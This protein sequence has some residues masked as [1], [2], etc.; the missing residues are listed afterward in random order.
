M[1]MREITAVLFDLDGTLLDSAPDLLATLDRLRAGLGLPPSDHAALRH[2]A[3]R[4]AAGLLQAGLGERADIDE[5]QLREKFFDDYERNLWLHTRAF[6]GVTALLAALGRSG[7]PMGIVTNKIS[8]FAE[9]I[10]VH[11]G[12]ESM[13]DC[14]VTGD[15]VARPKPDAEPVLTACRVLDVAPEQVMFLGDDRRDVD[16]GR[17][18]G[19]G[20]A[21]ATWGY[22]PPGEKPRQWGADALLARPADLLDMLAP[23]A[24]SL[25]EEP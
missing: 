12:W 8:R 24:A 16:A 4:G 7:I 3:S 18:A 15:R 22:I 21:V 25:R 19:A 11:A 2:H 1:A 6:E 10:L 20:T 9:P 5:E 14:L 13:F 23:Q 17:A